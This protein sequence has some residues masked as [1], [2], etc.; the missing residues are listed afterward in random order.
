MLENAATT[1]SGMYT[2]RQIVTFK[3]GAHEAAVRSLSA[4]PAMRVA[5]ASDFPDQIVDFEALGDAT[6]LVL[7]ELNVAV[8]ASPMATD[9]AFAGI[10]AAAEPDS[11][12]LAVEPET[13][14][15]PCADDVQEY[16]AALPLPPTASPTISG[17][18]APPPAARRRRWSRKPRLPRPLGG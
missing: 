11:P 6:T 15:F 7:P 10:A 17:A 2:G 8:V 1:G 13:F 4:G 12:I 9:P 5:S 18:P 16:C 3:P 14:V